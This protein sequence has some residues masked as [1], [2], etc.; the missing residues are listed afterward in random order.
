MQGWRWV[1]SELRPLGNMSDLWVPRRK[2]R[3]HGPL[4]ATPNTLDI[5]GHLTTYWFLRIDVD[6][7]V[8]SG[9]QEGNP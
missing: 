1:F 9:A 7:V 4:N 3:R 2:N 5:K 6:N 8:Q